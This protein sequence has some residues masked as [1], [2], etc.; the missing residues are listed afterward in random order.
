MI[1][2]DEIIHPR[3]SSELTLISNL[4]LRDFISVDFVKV[5]C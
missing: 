3:V 5:F 1:E 4:I 2:N